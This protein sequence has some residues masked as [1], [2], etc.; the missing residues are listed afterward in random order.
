MSAGQHG[1]CFEYPSDP[2]EMSYDSHNETFNS[3]LNRPC[4]RIGLA[5]E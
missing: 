5:V 4:D 1:E 3:R 2:I